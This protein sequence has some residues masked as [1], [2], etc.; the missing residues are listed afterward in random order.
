[1][2]LWDARSENLPAYVIFHDKTLAAL[3]A[4]NPQSLN[5][6][7]EVSGIGQ[8]KADKFGAEIL[9]LLASENGV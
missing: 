6:L 1:M 8:A 3:A 2:F 5:E 4:E 7:L 9:N